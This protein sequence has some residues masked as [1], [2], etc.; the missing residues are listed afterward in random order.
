MRIPASTYRIQLSSDFG[1]RDA[2]Q[3]VPYLAEMGISDVYLS[4]ILAPREGSTHGYDVAD[5]TRLNPALGTPE[6]FASL[7]EALDERNMG[8]LL[9]I[10][11]NHMAASP[12]NPWW[13]DVLE[14]G[15]ES[16]YAGYFDIDWN[17]PWPAARGKLLLPVLG[18]H[19]NAALE[20]GELQLE[21]RDDGYVVTY[22]DNVFPLAPETCQ[23]L[24]DS[25]IEAINEDP[26]ALD[27]I[28][29]AQ[30]YRLRYWK[31]ERYELNYRRFFN[32]SDLAGVRIE[33]PEVRRAMHEL[34]GELWEDSK[35][36]GLRVDHVDGLRDPAGYLTWLRRTFRGASGAKP[37][38]LV[39]KILAAHEELPEQWPVAGTTG[40]EYLN[41][42]NGV[43]VDPDGHRKLDTIYSQF[44][45]RSEGFRTVVYEKKRFVVDWLFQAEVELMQRDLVAMAARVRQGRDLTSRQL[46]QALVEISACMPVYRTYTMEPPVSADDRGY[47][48]AAVELARDYRPDL[49]SAAFD[50]VESVLLLEVSERLLKEAVEFVKTWQQF[51]PPLMAKGL[52]DTSLYV[53]NHLISLNTV[54]GE[55]DE[56]DVSLSEFHEFNQRR[57]EKWPGAMSSTSTHDSK[58]G[59]DVRNRIDVLS[60]MPD[61]FQARLEKW[62]EW[63]APKKMSPEIAEPPS[64]N[65]EMLLYQTLLG[66]WPVDEGQLEAYP[67]RLRQ[68]LI[69]SAREAKEKT[70]WHETDERHEYALVRFA[71][72]ILDDSGENRFLDDFREFQEELAFFGAMNSLSQVVLKIAS[73]GVPDFYQGSEF[74]NLTLVDPDNRRPVDYKA[75][76]EA[77]G[78]MQDAPE[79]HLGA[80][81]V[82]LLQDWKDA[83]IK[84]FVTW[85]AL[86]FRRQ[87]PALFIHAD[88]RPL[89]AR[90]KARPYLCAFA[91][92]HEHRHLIAVAPRRLSRLVEPFELPVG[93][94]WERGCLPLAEDLPSRWTDIVTG[95]TIEAVDRPECGLAM[96][97]VFETLPVALLY[98]EK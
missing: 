78:E 86:S 11:P 85:R 83:R 58:R 30:P 24:A 79:E 91:R 50:F 55:P 9:D 8:A 73:P 93:S 64:R 75:R 49:D 71:E 54:G 89:Y 56:G 35:I 65:E 81:A 60:E 21:S 23:T 66:S 14:H 44:T 69:K 38:V 51:T 34:I 52:E 94:V 2:E 53:Y 68:F 31:T 47:I 26:D 12:D 20:R 61:D 10:V 18:D 13:R 40:Y 3:L 48:E 22:F 92:R 4:P 16:D 32:I 43:F 96:D 80:Y 90:Q 36:T 59:E 37:Y 82:S 62:A 70:S 19:Y 28:L 7:V 25:D 42:L 97:E 45:G 29:D 15:P 95:K 84:Q 77:L 41:K 33:E 63:N 57:V 74:W 87:H 98:A 72:R 5:P 1:F 76:R 67:E 17:A 27:Q 88:Y 46:G 6:E 39:E